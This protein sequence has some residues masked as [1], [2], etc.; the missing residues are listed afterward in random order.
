M[1]T[2]SQGDFGRRVLRTYDDRRALQESVSKSVDLSVIAGANPYAQ[3]EIRAGHPIASDLVVGQQQACQMASMFLDLTDFTGRTYWDAPTDVANLA[4]A[5]LSAFTVAVE[6]WNGYVLGLRGDGLYA[7]FGPEQ[8]GTVPCVKALACAAYALHEVETSLNPQLRVRDIEPVKARAGADW[9][10][11]VFV[12]SGSAGTNEVNVVG[13]T[14][15]FAAKCEKVANSWEV[16]VGQGLVEQVPDRALFTEHAKS[17]KPFQRSYDRRSYRY[18]KY[19]WR[20]IV[21]EFDEE[22]VGK[23]L[24]SIIGT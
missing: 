17:P 19:S 22:I 15:N 18:Y 8:S 13:F 2:S 4:H 24:P 21:S 9:G 11:A 23:P 12:R 1:A 14:P 6:H 5:I 20:Q 16:I 10:T 3:A 7:G